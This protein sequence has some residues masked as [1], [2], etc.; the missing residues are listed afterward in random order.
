MPSVSFY[1]STTDTWLK[2]W[3]CMLPWHAIPFADPAYGGHEIGK[4]SP[5]G[6]MNGRTLVRY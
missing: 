3:V 4:R 2:G 5:I 1:K 6:K